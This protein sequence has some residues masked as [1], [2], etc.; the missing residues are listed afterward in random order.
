MPLIITNP[1]A[2]SGESNHIQELFTD[3]A[4]PDP[5]EVWVLRTGSAGIPDG[6]PI[7]MLLALTYT[8]NSGSS[9]TYQ[10]SYQ[11]LEGPIVRVALT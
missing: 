8:D 7:G 4:V 2:A 1:S 10:L 11:T 6:A 3:P 9:F 5:E